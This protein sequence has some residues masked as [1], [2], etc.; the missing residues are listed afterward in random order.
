MLEKI[1]LYYDAFTLP[2][3]KNLLKKY[4]I[5]NVIF[6]DLHINNVFRTGLLNGVIF[7]CSVLVFL[8]SCSVN[9][10]E[11][12]MEIISMF[13]GSIAISVAIIGQIVVKIPFSERVTFMRD[14]IYVIDDR[15]LIKKILN[16]YE[17]YDVYISGGDINKFLRRKLGERIKIKGFVGYNP[18]QS[19]LYFTNR[20][21]AML[22][23]LKY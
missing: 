14:R 9:T 6:D 7:G 19:I 21:D 11:Y 8:V 23:R 20:D 12:S 5:E 1:K 13:V 2:Y 16:E 17:F 4:D 3:R 10:Y 22:V 15:N 18:K